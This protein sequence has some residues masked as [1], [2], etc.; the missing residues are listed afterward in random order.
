MPIVNFDVGGHDDDGDAGGDDDDDD[1]DDQDKEVK[2]DGHCSAE[3][4]RERANGPQVHATSH[5]SISTPL[6]RIQPP[7][8]PSLLDKLRI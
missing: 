6:L 1:D 2:F 7:S 3:R 4:G 8:K 5:P